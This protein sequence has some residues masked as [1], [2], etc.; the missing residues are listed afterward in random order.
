MYQEP[1]GA[2]RVAPVTPSDS[3]DLSGGRPSVGVWVGTAG[4]VSMVVGGVTV[5]F[6]NIPA[7]GWIPAA[8]SRILATGT[9]AGGLIALYTQ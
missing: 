8:P 1:S 6:Q 3:N 7:G 4:N 2:T 9:T 5:L